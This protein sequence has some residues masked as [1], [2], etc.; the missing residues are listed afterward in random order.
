MKRIF[1]IEDNEDH[2]L[3]IRRGIET[4]DCEIRHFSDG[5]EALKACQQVQKYGGRP[6]LIL[7]DLQLPGM[8]GFDI[9]QAIKKMDELLYVPIVML[10]TSA[11]REEIEK[12][13][14]LG[15]DG[16]V[17]KSDDFSVLITKLKYIK[18]YWFSA[19]ELPFQSTQTRN[20][21]C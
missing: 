4:P 2:A 12:A 16:Y 17:V 10:T 21:S 8:N 5:L 19:V 14:E 18:D 3:L 9:L 20:P 6:D 15:A 11:R 7:L 1:M 13:Y